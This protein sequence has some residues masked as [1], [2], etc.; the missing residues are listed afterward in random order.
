MVKSKN[1]SF[2]NLHQLYDYTII[3]FFC[4][5]HCVGEAGDIVLRYAGEEERGRGLR[6]LCRPGLRFRDLRN[7]KTFIFC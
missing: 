6:E 4:H 5:L 1:I 7:S 2:F 3:C